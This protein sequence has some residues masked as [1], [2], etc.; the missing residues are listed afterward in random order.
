LLSI[1]GS[2]FVISLKYYLGCLQYVSFRIDLHASVGAKRQR[3]KFDR[4]ES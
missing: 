3:H 1:F 4:R 2:S